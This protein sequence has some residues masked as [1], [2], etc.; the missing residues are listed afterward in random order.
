M[1]F[2]LLLCASSSLKLTQYLMTYWR[3]LAT[4][5]LRIYLFNFD[6]RRIFNVLRSSS[7]APTP[8]F[9]KT[10]TQNVLIVLIFMKHSSLLTEKVNFDVYDSLLLVQVVYICQVTFL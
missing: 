6:I 1:I 7:S 10:S 9:I 5:Y 8:F 2:D 3:V 4:V